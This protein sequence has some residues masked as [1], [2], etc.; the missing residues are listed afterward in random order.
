[1]RVNSAATEIFFDALE[2]FPGFDR[3]VFEKTYT[4]RL[5]WA[6]DGWPA[7]LRDAIAGIPDPWPRTVIVVARSFSPGSL[8]LLGQRG[9]NW[10]DGAGNV[11]VQIPPGLFMS[12]IASQRRRDNKSAF[13]WSTS[14][15]AIAQH[16]LCHV[17]SSIDLRD[18]AAATRWSVPQTSNVLRAFDEKGWTKRH[19]P[20]RGAGVWR[21]VANPGALLE[22]WSAHLEEHRP[23]RYLGHR[24]MREPLRFLSGE[25]APLLDKLGDWAVTGWAGLELVAPF[26]TLVPALQVYVSTSRFRRDAAALFRQA[27]IREVEEGGNIEIW[28]MDLSVL[29]ARKE[30]GGIPIINSPRLYSDLLAI[31]GRAIDG[32]KHLRE[33]RLEY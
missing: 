4:L 22:A 5:V 1:M 13:S 32:A 25:L 33:I 21:S 14:S 16:L 26:I 9:A 24:L 23:R 18:L 7:E 31:G 30:A 17:E 29:V 6:K 19:G 27:G 20:A 11:S 28:E 12:K 10:V 8:E 3:A 15:V 2:A